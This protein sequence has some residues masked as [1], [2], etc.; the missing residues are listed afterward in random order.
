MK[1]IEINVKFNT[2]EA[3]AI[4]NE[5]NEN[6]LMMENE[7]KEC[8][9]GESIEVS[10]DRVNMNN[11]PKPIIK[12]R[13]IGVRM[14]N[15]LFNQMKNNENDKN[16]L[17]KIN[18]KLIKDCNEKM[19]LICVDINEE[20]AIFVAR[21][22]YKD[23]EQNLNQYINQFKIQI[24]ELLNSNI[25]LFIPK[26]KNIE[27]YDF[28]I[29]EISIRKYY[30]DYMGKAENNGFDVQKFMQ[31]IKI[32][33]F[34]YDFLDHYD[35]RVDDYLFEYDIEKKLTKEEFEKEYRDLLYNK[36]FKNEIDRIYNCKNEYKVEINPV[37][38]EYLSSD[39]DERIEILKALG[40]A[41][42]SND[43]IKNKKI[44]RM[45]ID[46]ISNYISHQSINV[47]LNNST[48]SFVLLEFGADRR[49]FSYDD[50]RYYGRRDIRTNELTDTINDLKDKVL[51]S[52][53]F[54]KYQD[55]VREGLRDELE[56]LNLLRINDKIIESKAIDYIYDLAKNDNIEVTDRLLNEVNMQK[57]NLTRL[58]AKNIYED[59]KD[60]IISHKYFPEYKD[61]YNGL[62]NVDNY[63]DPY[64]E[65]MSMPG[66]KNVKETINDIIDF[67]EVDKYRKEH[68][69]EYKNKDGIE[70][71][72]DGNNIPMNMLFM[73]NPGTAKTTVAKLI[74]KIFKSRGITK[75]D[76]TE[77]YGVEG[78]CIQLKNA[79][80]YAYGGILFIDEAYSLTQG[81]IDALVALMEEHRKDV[82]VILA[83]YTEAMLNFMKRNEGLNSRIKYKI[84]FEDYN[85]DELWEILKYIASARH[86]N[87]DEGVKEKVW[88]IFSSNQCDK[89]LGNGRLVRN[90]IDMALMKQ[91]KR[92]K[93]IDFKNSN[94]DIDTINT[95]IPEDFDIDYKKISGKEIPKIIGNTDPEIE[96]NNMIGIDEV[97]NMIDKIVASSRIEKVKKELDGDKN[98]QDAFV[99]CPM[100]LAFLGNPGTAKT[101]I[102]RLFARVLKKKGLIKKDTIVEVGRK[103]LVGKYV[104]HTAPLVKSQFNKAKGGIL[105][106]DEAYS[107]VDERT[108][109]FGDEAINT[110]IQEMEN[111]RDEV[112]VIFAGY[113][114]KMKKF[115][116]RNEGF[117]SR[118][119][120][121]IEFKDYNEEELFKI[122]NKIIKDNGLIVNDEVNEKVKKIIKKVMEKDNFGN[123]RFIRSLIEKAKLN[124]N[125]RLGKKDDYHVFTKEELN[126]IEASDFDDIS[127]DEILDNEKHN[128]IGF[129]A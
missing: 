28:N 82:I 62:G 94:I 38:Y 101:T 37:H 4:N 43:R 44:L 1:H 48:G 111:M 53:Y 123:G 127:F 108:G 84:E 42:Y 105:F 32:Y 79:F 21:I 112:I 81:D 71:R 67:H 30:Y 40:V 41:L 124:K 97:K 56:Q 113:T 109:S 119:S 24:E 89:E 59:Y 2:M 75:T 58:D 64:E 55:K 76:R 125:Y 93:K 100:H 22:D 6:K 80:K 20:N 7:G 36:D 83:G 23:I 25:D 91:A 122:F 77:F 126:T 70:S 104:G 18:D 15:A 54:D 87:I 61:F 116:E 129:V 5:N 86:M 29:K 19:S 73:G 99:S 47:L 52:F 69:L 120:Y 51:F 117:R 115:I 49:K 66:L 33:D 65:L 34:N 3:V 102:A 35:S 14:R 118:I 39:Q 88:P 103:D 8:S 17:N 74:A 31:M 107:L 46:I 50:T 98:I 9:I 90:I 12:K 106:I 128:E 110:I 27:S 114:D 85:E 13:P 92:F 95:L 68:F 96:L 10:A 57:N 16:A 72:Y 45:K 60:Y 63:V 121:I 26:N 78:R 11:S